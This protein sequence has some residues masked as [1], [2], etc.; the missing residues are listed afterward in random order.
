MDHFPFTFS[1][2]TRRLVRFFVRFRWILRVDVMHVN[3]AAHIPQGFFAEA[4]FFPVL[5]LPE[6]T[7]GGTRR[8]IAEVLDGL[9]GE[10]CGLA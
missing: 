4:R 5:G 7:T 3:L 2:K 1:K 9:R 6:G 10:V 8:R